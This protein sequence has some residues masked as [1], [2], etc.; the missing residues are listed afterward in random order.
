MVFS[1]ENRKFKHLLSIKMVIIKLILESLVFAWK[2]LRE[3]LLR[4]ALSLLGVTVGIF[5]IISVFTVVDSLE[6]SIR[7]S[8]SFLGDKVVRVEKWPW[9]FEDNYPWWK[10]FK[11]PQAT[12][13]EYAFLQN[14]V[15]Q[16][17]AICIFAEK[18]NTL[19]QHTNNSKSD[20]NL[21]G[22][23][24]QYNEVYEMPIELGRYFSVQEIEMARNVAII[25]AD[26]ADALFPNA[27]AIGK[28]ISIS[29]QKYRVIAVLSRQG[30]NLI[31][32]PSIDDNG[33]IPYGSFQK[34]YQTN[35]RYGGIASTIALKA[36]EHDAECKLLENELEGLMRRKR[37]LRPLEE[38]DFALNRTE[39]FQSVL[40]NIFGVIGIA[41]WLIGSFSILVGG[42]GIANIMF[43]SVKERTVIIGIQ[44]ALGAKNYFILFQFLF[45]AIFL[46]L[47]GGGL[48][49]LLVYFLSFISIGSLELTLSLKNMILGL[50]VASGVGVVAGLLPAFSAAHMDPVEAIRSQ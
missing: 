31:D 35:Q 5:A 38:S 49:L 1:N 23:S 21:V 45:E 28:N 26:V 20:V 40:D 44:K 2:A 3:N 11:R 13:D 14:N 7:E 30:E 42:F 47:L 36:Y 12:T 32:A 29:A 50:G 16:A 34:I 27:S 37:G 19:L 9:I 24:Y 43:V 10:Y 17:T 18:G 15:T 25:G 48:G 39:A 4:T 22:M 6:N 41:G 46:S 8:M 33:F